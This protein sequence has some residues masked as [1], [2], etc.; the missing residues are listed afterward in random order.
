[1]K[2]VKSLKSKIIMFIFALIFPL[3]AS[4]LVYS[5]NNF[6]TAKA[7]DTNSASTQYYSGYTSEISLTNGNFNSGSSTYSISTSLSGWS[8]QVTNSNTTAGIINTGNTFQTH[9]ASTY[10]LSKNPLSKGVDK[11]ILMINS[12][13][14]DSNSTNTSNIYKTKRQGYKS[15]SISL[16]A[17]SFYSFQVSFKNDTNY[18]PHTTYAFY[19]TTN[20]EVSIDSNSF[21]SKAFD[22]YISFTYNSRAYYLHKTL[23]EHE[24]LTEGLT[25]IT[26][27]YED[28]Q[29]VGFMKDST[30]V[31]VSTENITKTEVEGKTQINVNNGATL[32]TCPIVYDAETKTYDVP[33]GTRYYTTKTEYTSL[34]DYVYGS[35]YLSGLTDENGEPVKADFEQ[36]SSKEWITF[37]FF[38]AT[39]NQSQNVSLDLWLGTNVPGHESSGV[40]F[41]DD[42]HV[43]KY[44]ENSFWKAY[45]SY[46]GKTYTQ[47]I[48][49]TDGSLTT[50][51]T[52]CVDFVDLRSTK[53]L[54][55]PDSNFDFE[56]GAFNDNL[57][58]LKNWT[59]QG[60]GNA[61]VFDS[62]NANYFKSVT[63]YDFVGSNLSCEVEIDEEK[64]N[65]T[66]N[67]YVLALWANNNTV[68]VKSQNIDVVSNEIYKI[69]AYYKISKLTSGN[70][71]MIV[72]END[73]VIKQ[74]G[75]EAGKNYTL[76]GETVSSAVSTNGDS[77]FVN[78]Y[79]V[80]EF[81]V[82]GGAL[83]D[84]SINLSLSLGK[85]DENATG[86]VVFDDITIE[87]ASSTEYENATNSVE[88]NSYSSS[89]IVPNGN[90]NSVTID[91][92]D[93]PLSAKD[94]TVENGTGMVYNGVFNVAHYDDYR[95]KYNELAA[96]NVEDLNNPY[97]WAEYASNPNSSTGSKVDNVY[98]LANITSSWQKLTSS[99]FTLDADSTYKLSFK[100]KTTENGK[101]KF[102]IVGEDVI[103]MFE[104]E[105]LSSNG[106][107]KTYEVYIKSFSG[108]NQISMVIDFGDENSTLTGFAYLDNF[109]LQSIES[110]EYDAKA[111]A[112]VGANYGIVDMTN[113]Y[114]NL[115]TNNITQDITNGVNSPAY[116][117][118]VSSNPDNADILGGIILSDRW[119][120]GSHYYI[121]KE[122]QNDEAKKVFYINCNGVGSYTI[123]SNYNLDLKADSYY[124]LSFKLKTNFLYTN[125]G[126][127]LDK[128]KDYT[129]GLTF[130][131]TGFDY[132]TEL[133]SNEEY[134]TYTIYFHPTEDTSSKI[135]MALICDAIETQGSMVLYDL[136]LT[137]LEDET[138]FNKANTTFNA[139]GYDIN[140]DRVF[141]ASVQDAEAEN[142]DE[143]PEEGGEET[144][145]G[146]NNGFE[147]LLMISSL[148]TAGAIIIAVVGS[149]LKKVKLKKIERKKKA[150]Y[151]RKESLNID[152][153][154]IKA[155]Q[156][157]DAEI[158]EI[159]NTIT[160]FQTELDNLEKVHKQKILNLREKDKGHV[161]KET[162]RE[163]KLFAQKRTVI[164]E[165]IDSLNKQIEQHNSPEY[166]LSLERKVYL[167]EENKQKELQKLS[168][169]LNKEKSADK[170]NA[171]QKSSKK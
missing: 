28:E 17:N 107:W 94:W 109:D 126:T 53:V 74:Y 30:P 68:S 41:F 105:N 38:V 148:I 60:A 124:S 21:K 33:S 111:E 2:K 75:L 149:I 160:K 86:C 118:S 127:E 136:Q 138:E 9:M 47:E 45:N 14:E 143:T 119:S 161:S 121:E 78:N 49:D 50:Q 153:I 168:K 8:G 147:W 90:F 71:Y 7:D 102:S 139:N 152:A 157:R 39:G 83:Y 29:Y 56:E 46:Y 69:K 146:T 92:G 6:D 3:S 73:S 51:E 59:K 36:V 135:H 62:R 76:T 25:N 52:E 70:V 115:P 72:E 96:N 37:Y 88:L 10:H 55:Y 61:Q 57:S 158:A 31:Y 82:K 85:S 32:Y 89:Q 162:D 110:T 100:Y 23:D 48:T 112:G 113:F 134:Q 15:S 34:N 164:V 22:D 4:G 130:G 140:K 24:T 132:M 77:N 171:N 44:S 19:S 151:D 101:I 79:G 131:L 117:G 63:G 1:M 154:K 155:K 98:M 87:K 35:I 81:Y 169:K 103:T 95:A 167:Q 163:F 64:I 11:Y 170:N 97:Y 129:Y 125:N 150:S 166:L 65:I 104:V 142:P 66:P 67:N 91:N 93:Y 128:N 123:E 116:S 159:K 42:C 54:N 80:I 137:V 13:T 145:T 84:S 165:K 122:N 5:L 26:T 114:L 106:L 58:S 16:D 12:R 133:V 108:A 141:V 120:E 27:F 43:Y 40:V 99:T 20:K 18:N 144:T 156:Q